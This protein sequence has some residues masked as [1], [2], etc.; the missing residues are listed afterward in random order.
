VGDASCL[1]LPCG[2]GAMTGIVWRKRRIGKRSSGEMGK[3]VIKN[4][5]KRGKYEHKGQ[6]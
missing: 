4:G 3:K 1:F 2:G 5:K 6:K